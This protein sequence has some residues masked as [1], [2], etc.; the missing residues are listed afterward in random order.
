MIGTTFALVTETLAP[1]PTGEAKGGNATATGTGAGN[2]TETGG[3]NATATGGATSGAGR[4]ANGGSL[5]RGLVAVCAGA[6]MLLM[7]C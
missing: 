5:V 6:V 3:E 7:W 1:Q 4:V 2:A